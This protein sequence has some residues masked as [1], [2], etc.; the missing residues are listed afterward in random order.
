MPALE[1]C[2]D[3]EKMKFPPADVRFSYTTAFLYGKLATDTE[4]SLW[5]GRTTDSVLKTAA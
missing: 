3:G 5:Q 1:Q 4:D 2:K